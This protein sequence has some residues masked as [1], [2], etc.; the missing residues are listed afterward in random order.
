M[1]GRCGTRTSSPVHEIRCTLIRAEEQDL[2]LPVQIDELLLDAGALAWNE[3]IDDRLPKNK[4]R[5]ELYIP[6]ITSGDGT[7]V[8]VFLETQPRLCAK[9]TVIVRT[10]T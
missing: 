4:V 9:S 8:D 3:E 5:D 6:Y 7:D 1:I 10:N 2:V